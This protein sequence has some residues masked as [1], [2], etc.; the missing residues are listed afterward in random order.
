MTAGA[1]I[2]LLAGLAT[3]AAA[4][5]WRSFAPA[6]EISQPNQW[7]RPARTIRTT[8]RKA[9]PAPATEVG[10]TEQ[11]AKAKQT[12]AT[13]TELPAKVKETLQIVVS[14][15]RQQLTLYSG[16]QPIAHSR[17]STGTASHPT[18]TGIF[19][20]IQKDRWHRSNLYNDAPMWYMQRITW[21]G[22]AMHQGIVPNHPAS[23]GCIRL[24]E[25]FARQLWGI[26]KLGV[27]VVVTRGDVTPVAFAHP[28][29]FIYK[30]PDP[31]EEEKPVEQAA[32]QSS[33][34]DLVRHAYRALETAQAF[35]KPGVTA[36]DVPKLGESAF[37]AMARAEKPTPA[38]TPA[39]AS[40]TSADVVK[41][42]YDAFDMG[43]Y[44]R[45][46]SA[47]KATAATP[48]D[49]PADTVRPLKPGPIS[50]FISRKEGKVFV[51]KGF[52][53]VFDAP[54]TIE[55][56]EQP[57]GT[58]VYTALAFND[59]NASLRWTAMTVPNNLSRPTPSRKRGEPVQAAPVGPASNAAAALDR[60]TIPQPALDRI[61]GLISA[62]ASL[63]ISDQ[64]LGPETGKGTD[65]IVLTR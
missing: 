47:A 51:R 8:P 13:T 40:A 38:P 34:T 32:A 54:V 25:A 17:V 6:P 44:R 27:R 16:S 35:T 7:E 63:V 64:G 31:I 59:D 39:P 19:S 9:K 60:I 10:A 12:A 65:F 4:F 11:P 5:G 30:Q 36:T 46:K 22:V 50:V 28:K 55:H 53:P 42:A 21:S 62:G 52:E 57:L 2:V 45:G 37:T 26:T 49:Q 18:P 29:L 23:H 56:P 20:V 33:S 61:S 1:G 43:N 41:T 48:V 14:L 24:P 15:D 3:P 58:H